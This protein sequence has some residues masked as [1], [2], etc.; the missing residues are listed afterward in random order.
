ME[1]GTIVDQH[2]QELYFLFMLTLAAEIKSIGPSTTLPPNPHSETPRLRDNP[3]NSHLAKIAVDS[4]IVETTED[5]L[6]LV[7]PAFAH[8]GLL[9][10]RDGTP[11]MRWPPHGDRIASARLPPSMESSLAE[12]YGSDVTDG[13]AENAVMEEGY[14]G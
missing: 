13:P 11:V 6:M 4:K 8:H 9:P 12:E 2:A 1:S 10:D 14:R 5:G 3:L 7:V